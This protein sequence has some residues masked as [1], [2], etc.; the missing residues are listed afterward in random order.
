[1]IR[2]G[3]EDYR[4]FKSDKAA[5]RSH[6]YRIHNGKI[7]KIYWKD[8]TAGD[9][10]LVPRDEEIPADILLLSSS[11]DDGSA[12]MQTSNLDGEKNLKPR[13]SIHETFASIGP[14]K[15]DIISEESKTGKMTDE[16]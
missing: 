5:N 6:T 10:V 3:I 12:Q 16:I 7:T 4:R 15:K 8:A 13:F 2:E 1:M 14:I 11:S 9:L